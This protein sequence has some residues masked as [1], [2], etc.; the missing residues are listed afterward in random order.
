M[1]GTDAVKAA[2]YR[3]EALRLAVAAR[4]ASFQEDHGATIKRA[5]AFEKYLR[6]SDAH[7]KDTP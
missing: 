5:K 7:G 1:N 4:T 3:L 6:G 2:E